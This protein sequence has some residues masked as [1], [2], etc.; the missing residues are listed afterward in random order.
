MRN[1]AASYGFGVTLRLILLLLIT[2]ISAFAGGLLAAPYLDSLREASSASLAAGPALGGGAEGQVYE[3]V[4]PSVVGVRGIGGGEPPV[5][6]GAETDAVPVSLLPDTPGRGQGSGFVWDKGGYIVTNLHVV[7]GAQC[8]EVTF[9]DGT[10]I[11]ATLHGIDLSTDLAVLKVNLPPERLQP[12]TLGDSANL[13]VGQPALA[14]GA[15][16]GQ[17]FTM[18]GGSIDAL[19]QTMQGC[20]SCYPIADVIRTDM[21]LTPENS[22]GPL[23]NEQGE[24]IGINTWIISRN[25]GNSGISFALSSKAMEQVVPT[26]ISNQE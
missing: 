8:I 6:A 21:R 11:G 24:V 5:E 15:P 1:D 17:T 22:G 3:K 18:T 26:L 20:D 13:E 9:A 4:L 7:E 2:A 10:E 12:I 25:S 23:L 14:M 19:D 16:S